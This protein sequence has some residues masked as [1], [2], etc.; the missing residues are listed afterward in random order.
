[1]SLTVRNDQL[2]VK[3]LLVMCALLST[4]VFAGVDNRDV[5]DTVV[6]R[7]ARAV[8]KWGDA[9]NLHATWLFWCLVALSL[10]WTFGM[11]ALRKADIGEFFAEFFRFTAFTG[12]YLWLLQTGPSFAIKIINGFMEIGSTAGNMGKTL[13]P[14]DVAD[15]GFFIFAK[16]VDKASFYSPVMSGVGLLIAAVILVVFALVGI[17]M[18]LLLIS[19]WI[20]AYAGVIFLGFGGSK[21]TSDMAIGYFKTVLNV[22]AQLMAMTLIIGIGKKFALDYYGGM[23]GSMQLKE[24]G[25]ML[26]VA[27]TMLS[28][29]RTIPAQIGSLA[30]G[31]TGALGTGFGAGSAV[32]ATAM[33]GAAI[34][35]AGAAIAA[36]AT[37]IAGGAQALMAAFSNGS[38]AESGAGSA[39]MEAAANSS[40]SGNDGGGNGGGRG[41][42]SL[43]TAMGD[44]SENSGG[45]ASSSSDGSPESEGGNSDAESQS[46]SD[47]GDVP[48]SASAVGGIAAKV[49][50]AAVGT[51]KNLAQGSWD[52][53]KAS[54][55]KRIGQTT[56]GKIARA[57]K[58]RNNAS[59]GS[60]QSAS[61]GDNTLSAGSSEV[62]ADAEIAA[63][64][65]R[66]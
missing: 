20:L 58:A 21:W 33:A 49:G 12:F 61:F 39:M 56:G 57:I 6:D 44:S 14:S 8:D 7:Y 40:G 59:G 35:T 19:A 60:N 15:I 1:M 62:D 30:G 2:Y 16:M 43:A 34:A 23:R 3:L 45:S 5:L 27:V 41:S 47:T 52:V 28:L 17:N 13:G 18:L 66:D 22:A 46:S 25:V 54:A 64:R 29:V 10:V 11:M 24:L 37:N 48:R 53:A 36:G 32:A 4:P 63:F 26:V 50:R 42:D 65:D 9:I 51:A 38:G 55:M 31:N